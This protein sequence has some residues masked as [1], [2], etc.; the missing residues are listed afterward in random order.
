MAN[1]WLFQRIFFDRS[2][3]I[4]AVA[5]VERNAIQ[6][7]LDLIPI[8]WYFRVKVGGC[9]KFVTTRFG[10]ID[11]NE[12]DVI[13]LPKGI[14]G[15]SQ[16]TRY[17]II[18]KEE[19]APFKWFQS[20]EDPNVAFVVMDP[21]KVFPNYKLEIDERELEELNYASSKDLITYVIVTVPQDATQASAD[22]LGPLVINAR[23]RLAKQAVMS[24]SPYTTRH[25]LLDEFKKR[26][27]RKYLNRKA[28]AQ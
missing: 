13:I 1:H 15:F 24:N 9:M 12:N 17:V 5:G 11:C 22:L 2:P 6:T 25:Y 14:L 26:S 8:R 16:L 10:E 20:V 18:E 4:A 21:L 7:G 23:K 27:R 19:A 28:S 3:R